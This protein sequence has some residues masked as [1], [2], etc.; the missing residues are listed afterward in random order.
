[1]KL[2][3]INT[4]FLSVI[5]S[6]CTF[7]AIS[8][9]IKGTVIDGS[10]NEPIIGATIIVANTTK[11]TISLAEGA[12]ELQ[13]PNGVHTLL[14][15]FLG[16]TKQ[17]I[18]IEVKDG[19]Q[20]LTIIM[21]M[22]DAFITN[23][24]KVVGQKNLE[25]QVALS[26]ER[27]ISVKA[28]EN[29]GA[30]ELSL[31]GISN[32]EDGVKKMTGISVASAGQIIVRG[33]GDRYSITTLNGQPIASPNPDNKLI[34]LN[35]FPSSTVKNI[36]VSKVYDAR[37]YADYS[38]AHIDVNT[39]ELG[40]ADFFSLGF[41]VGGD[42][43]T[44]GKDFYRMDHVSLFS[45][46]NADALMTMAKSDAQA[47]IVESNQ[48]DTDF[49]TKLTKGLPNFSGN[50]GFGRSFSLGNQE[51]SILATGAVS[52][53]NTATTDNFEKVIQA[54]GKVSDDYTYDS[55]TSELKLASL[56]SISTTLGENDHIGYTMFYARNASDNLQS[57]KGVDFD[58]NN[59]HGISSVTHIY[60]LI[61]Q[62]LGGAHYFG[63]KW[64]IDWKMAYNSSS[65][66]EPD[67]RQVMFE[68]TGDDSN[69]WLFT[70]KSNVVMRYFGYLNESDINSDFATNFHFG[71]SNKLTFGGAYKDKVRDFTS[72]RYYYNVNALGSATRT[73]DDLYN[74]SSYLNQENISNGNIVVTRDKQDKD[75]YDAGQT[76][77]SAFAT[78]DVNFEKLLLNMGL[79]YE[80]LNQYINYNT[81]K[82]RTIIANDLFPSLN[83]RY[84][85]KESEQLRLS[86]SRTV[87][88]PQFIEMAPYEY[89]QSYGSATIVGNEELENGY[90][91]N[92]DLRYEKFFTAGDM[93]SFTAYY[94]H[95]VDP[96]ERTQMA[97]GGG[98]IQ[99][100][101]NAESG[102]ATGVEFEYKKSLFD[103]LSFGVNGSYMYTNVTLSETGNYTNKERGLQGAS[104]YLFN[105]DLVYSPKFNSGKT[106]NFALLYNLQGPR[107][108]AVG[109][110]ECGDVYQ[111]PFH[112]MTLAISHKLNDLVSLK[113]E[114]DNLLNQAEVYEQ[115]VTSLGTV[116]EVGRRE[117][118]MGA[119]LGV[120]F[121]F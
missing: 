121:N 61:T 5:F 100:F 46:S 25:S 52:S 66:D 14:V 95:L 22:D 74:T 48:F 76:I 86:L 116:E 92:A 82:N 110:R 4:L 98:T 79:R 51:L 109:V 31:K 45:Q 47:A 19:F 88:R 96:I 44:V 60:T 63:D 54:D 94:K 62:Q 108:Y 7:A 113:L 10:N 69:M 107:I 28:I 39:K 36:T 78:V 13:L 72:V 70:D 6:I 101:Q 81:D 97:Q 71:Q 114:F 53:S 38:G 32:V 93:I 111:K 27:E 49:S 75:Q 15:S 56:V 35:V 9:E 16:Y 104:P 99:T 17:E 84:L 73:L 1:M 103:E 119:M 117:Y 58:L 3:F 105:A 18:E 87:T 90:N 40:S 24:V 83:A 112:M 85:L 11:S 30:K 102:L 120:S 2:K 12:F 8:A 37:S 115:E 55:Y 20:P 33:L 68:T 21:S 42:F 91:W 43:S 34:P 64:D 118:G 41:G 65:A 29:I 26:K 59:T 50:L 89:K 57:K 80:H 77:A 67:R 106:L 23:D